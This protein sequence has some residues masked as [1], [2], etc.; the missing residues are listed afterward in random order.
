MLRIL[1][2]YHD[3][4]PKRG[5]IED[6]VLTLCRSLPS[7]VV[8][9]I[10]TGADS[11]STREESIEGIRTIRVGSWGRYYTPLCPSMPGYFRRVPS[12]IIHIHMPCPMGEMAFL[13]ARPAVPLILSYHNDI[14]RQPITR[15]LYGP[16][17]KRILERAEFILVSTSDYRET[18]MALKDF[19]GKCQTVP[20][21][22]DI[23]RFHPTPSVTRKAQELQNRYAKPIILFVG[24]LCYYKGLEYLIPAMEKLDAALLIVGTGPLEKDFRRL[25]GKYGGEIH[26]VGFVPEQELPAYYYASQ[27]AILPSTARSEAFGLVQ[28]HAQACSRPVIATDLP[29]VSTVTVHGKT[30]LIVPPRS[31]DAIVEA[32]SQLLGSRDLR[33][34]MGSAGYQRV[35]ELYQAHLMAERIQEVYRKVYESQ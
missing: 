10:L 31:S 7:T 3:C 25:A 19:T 5:G 29:G 33:E 6:H 18:S 32:A 21:G 23:E 28:L 16:F 12:D 24:R 4:Y 9:T 30:G 17:L 15:R 14:V 35:T 27:M 34:E 13:V 26:L 11:P 2:V 1:Q 22:I 8:S 20:Y